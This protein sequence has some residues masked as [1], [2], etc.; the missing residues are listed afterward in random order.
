MKSSTANGKILSNPNYK[1]EF[2]II[3]KVWPKIFN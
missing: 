3:S 2:K 1:K